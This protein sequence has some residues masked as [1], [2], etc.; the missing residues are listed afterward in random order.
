MFETMAQFV[1]GDHL[2]GRSFDPPIG[3]AGNPRLMSEGR[4]PYATR[5]VTSA[6]SSIPTSSGRRSS[7]VSAAS[8]NIPPIPTCTTSLRAGG[9]STRWKASSPTSCGR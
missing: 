7:P 2:G 4:R 3:E 1:L 6:R 9:M 5:D 8:I